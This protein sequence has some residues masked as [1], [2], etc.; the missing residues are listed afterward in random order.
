MFDQIID[1]KI[2]IM[3]LIRSKTIVKGEIITNKTNCLNGTII[4]ED[5]VAGNINYHLTYIK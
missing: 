1:I 4:E 2:K 3:S 5:I